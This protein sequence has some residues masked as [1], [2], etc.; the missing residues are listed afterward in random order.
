MMIMTIIF[1][2]VGFALLVKGANY[3]V[4]GSAALAKNFRVNPLII[5][6]TI[7]ACGT[8][9]PELA[10]SLSAAAEGSSEIALS[11][12]IGSNTFNLLG[13]L[14]ICAVMSPIIVEKTIIKRDFAV[15]TLST[16][17]LF[18][19]LAGFTIVGKIPAVGDIV[20]KNVARISGLGGA[21][22]LGGYVMYIIYIFMKTQ[23][24]EDEE[25][26]GVKSIPNKKCVL[27]LI[28]GVIMIILGGKTVVTSAKA[29]ALMA[30]MSETLIGLTIVAIGTSLPELV[31]SVVATRKGQLGIALGNVLGSNIFNLLFILGVSAII[32]PIYVNVASVYDLFILLIVTIITWL[33]AFTEHKLNKT[34]GVIML[35]MYGFA[36]IYAII[37]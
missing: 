7:V 26:E 1:L 13:I 17:L 10:V 15:T 31:T 24:K 25:Y 14:G 8:S 35:V 12:I 5:G 6:L 16:V 9:A 37:R 20:T 11:N 2:M 34:E 29:L 32:T 28:A 30:G 21:L 27:Y 19:G 18:V 22:L 3:F 23:G 4:D 33:F 36:M